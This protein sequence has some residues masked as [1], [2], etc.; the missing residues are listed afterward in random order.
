MSNTPIKQ[1]SQAESYLLQQFVWFLQNLQQSRADNHAQKIVIEYDP[2]YADFDIQTN[3]PQRR[4]N[5]TSRLVGE[6]IN[7]AYNQVAYFEQQTGKKL[8]VFKVGYQDDL[9]LVACAYSDK[10]LSAQQ[11]QDANQG[12]EQADD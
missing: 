8:S 10:P 9:Y 5:R 4:K 2:E 7:W 6:V 3:E 1:L 11:A 12:N